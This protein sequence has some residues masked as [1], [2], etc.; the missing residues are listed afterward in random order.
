MGWFFLGVDL[1]QARDFTAVAIVERAEVVGEWDAAAYAYR[2]HTALRLRF[3]ER[4]TLGTPYME[5]AEKVA[6]FARSGELAGRCTLVVDAT[7]VGRP[8]VELIRKAGPGCAMMPVTITGGSSETNEGEY[9]GV[10]KKDLITGVQV[11]LQNSELQI[12]AGIPHGET[13]AAEMAEVR[14]KVTA[15]GNTQYGAWREGTHDDLVLA[16]A[17]ACW[18]AQKRH[19][20]PLR[21]EAAYWKRAELDAWERGFREWAEGRRG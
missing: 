4:M 19:P 18:A 3:L 9:H 5:V 6:K 20:Y 1:G 21:G 11:L 14:V 7:G 15:A 12:A 16:V 17:L 2:K 10:P 8:V 13:L